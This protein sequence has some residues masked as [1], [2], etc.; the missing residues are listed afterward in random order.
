M[1]VS[2][3]KTM[4]TAVRENTVVYHCN[5]T[6]TAVRAEEARLIE[7]VCDKRVPCQHTHTH[8]C[9]YMYVLL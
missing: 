3:C 4:I 1:Y 8:V 2:H 7:D 9:I 6:I 5:T